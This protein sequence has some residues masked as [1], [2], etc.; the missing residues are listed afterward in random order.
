MAYRYSEAVMRIVVAAVAVLLTTTLSALD[1]GP[2]RPVG[3]VQY[4]LAPSYRMRPRVA[5]NESGA[6][7]AWSDTRSGTMSVYA[8]RLDRDGRLLDPVGQLIAEDAN[9]LEVV[10]TGTTW[11]VV[12]LDLP[13]MLAR[14]V[15]AEGV[16]GAPSTILDTGWLIHDTVRMATNGTS[17]AL[18]TNS[19]KGRMLDRDGRVQ[20]TFELVPAP[21]QHDFV[22]DVAA[23]GDGYGIAHTAADGVVFRRLSAGGSVGPVQLLPGSRGAYTPSIGSDGSSFVVVYDG[24][25]NLYAQ[26]L[27]A[28]GAPEGERQTVATYEA[29]QGANSPT[30]AWGGSDYLVAFSRVGEPGDR[31]ADPLTVR[32]TRDGAV[33][34][35]AVPFAAPMENFSRTDAA[36]RPDGSG[37]AVSVSAEQVLEGCIFDAGSAVPR[38]VRPLSFSA[39]AQRNVRTA[40]EGSTLITGWVESTARTT[41]LRL[42]HGAGGP[43]VVVATTPYTRLMDVVL[44]RSVVWVVWSEGEG[45]LLARRYTTALEAIDA[46]PVTL[47]GFSGN[48][49]VK[50]AAGGGAL[51]VTWPGQIRWPGVFCATARPDGD[52]LAVQSLDIATPF[53]APF[54][55]A[56]W[57]GSEFVVVWS[58]AQFDQWWQ[59]P[60]AVPHD[61]MALRVGA[62]GVRRDETP[63]VISDGQTV[64]HRALEAAPADGTVLVAWQSIS[65]TWAPGGWTPAPGWPATT[66]VT[67]F[68]GVERPAARVVDAAGSRTLLGLAEGGGR[69]AVLWSSA[70]ALD[71]A[72]LA[73]DLTVEETG[74]LP[75]AATSA[76]IAARG[77]Q[78][79]IAYSRLVEEPEYGRVERVF[80]RTAAA[81]RR[82]AAR[83]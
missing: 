83:W 26:K 63:L 8:A 14:T 56:A 80:L 7:V 12:Y 6:L 35:P 38:V 45:R 9:A 2:E 65:L 78:P 61:V 51:L 57:N 17:V 32:L 66:A 3:P 18:V 46:E 15:S 62:D 48:V 68:E 64:T 69:V 21:T 29:P 5:V 13:L 47:L 40:G 50:A 77:G 30:V 37:V 27:D 44:D 25:P 60:E 28:S 20:S 52:G 67:R 76:G 73:G 71:Y 43:S 34:A 58:Q 39:A 42:A 70:T 33:A 59:I 75:V 55:A 19:G 31:F 10:W 81:G 79:S 36:R 24:W 23:F 11:L 1:L 74:G 16:V 22:I 49:T 53:N 72:M 54:S 4:E 82:R 41:E